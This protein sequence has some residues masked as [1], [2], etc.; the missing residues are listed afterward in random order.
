MNLIAKEGYAMTEVSMPPTAG[1]SE[2]DDEDDMYSWSTEKPMDPRLP[3]HSMETAAIEE[4]LLDEAETLVRK[5]GYASASFLQAHMTISYGRGQKLLTLLE[6][7]GVVGHPDGTRPRTVLAVAAEPKGERMPKSP[8]R[9]SHVLSQA[10]KKKRNY[11]QQAVSDDLIARAREFIL[12]HGDTRNA[13]LRQHLKVHSQTV[14]EITRHLAAEGILGPRRYGK[15][16]EILAPHQE[17]G[18]VEEQVQ[19]ETT[20]LSHTLSRKDRGERLMQLIAI[21]GKDSELARDVLKP[22]IED[23]ATLND[24]ESLLRRTLPELTDLLAQIR[25]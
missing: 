19:A 6:Q 21:V 7:R 8:D 12:A 10:E 17:K 14:T 9:K 13:A 5:H 23:L 4:A 25:K 1:V 3:I 2:G 15:P 20:I 22:T 11:G 18:T 24:M 16:R